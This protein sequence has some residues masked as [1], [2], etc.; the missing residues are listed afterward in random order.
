MTT[1]SKAL[2]KKGL[3][4]EPE[5][6]CTTCL[7]WLGSLEVQGLELFHLYRH[8][9]KYLYFQLRIAFLFEFSLAAS[10][11]IESTQLM[12]RLSIRGAS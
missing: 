6:I 10:A 1:V 9:P 4:I 2:T 5:L 7:L 8:H 12:D 3:S 11:P